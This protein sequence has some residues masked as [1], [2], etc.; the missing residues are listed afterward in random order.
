MRFVA[1]LHIHSRYARATS[2]ELTPENL[3]KWAALKGITIVGTGDFTHPIWFEELQEKLEPAETGLYRLKAPWRKAVEPVLPPSCRHDVRFLLSVEISSIYKKNGRTRKV[4]NLVILP[5]LTYVEAFNRR[6]GTIGNLKADGRPILGLDSRTLLEI[7]LEV[8]PEVLFIPAHIWTP[9]F[10]VLGSES[11]FDSLEE[12]F[13]DLLP[14]IF[15]LET[16][17]SSDPLMNSRLSALDRFVMVSNSDAHSPQKLARE[18]TCFDTELS[19][20]AMYTALKERDRQRFTGT[21]EFYPEEGKYHYDGHRKCQVRWKPAQTMQTNG[22]CPHCGGKLT[23]GVLHR[24]ERLADRPEEANPVVERPFEYLIPLPEVIGAALGVGP[25]SKRVTTIYTKLLEQLGP[26]L[27]ILRA[28]PIADIAH[29]GEPLVAEALRRM[30]TGEVEIQA[31]YD[32]E[33]GTIQIFTATEREQLKGQRALFALPVPA[34]SR[35]LQSEPLQAATPTMASVLEQPAYTV[36]GDLDPAQRQAVEAESGPVVVVAGPGAG[37]TRTLTQR[38]AYLIRQRGVSSGQILAVTFTK[39]AAAEMHS[40]L[41]ALLPGDAIDDLCLGTFHR[42]ALDLMRLYNAAPPKT[43]LDAWEARQLLATALR[44][45]G[46]TIRLQTAQQ[47]ISL[48]KAAGLRPADI[49]GD[50]ALQAAYAAY[51]AQLHAY[52]A[53]DYDDILLDFLAGLETQPDTAAQLRQRFPYILVDEFQDVNAV[54]Y[55]LVKTLAGDGRGLFVI[56]DP[57]Q[58]IYGFRGADP[59]HF[60]QLLQ[61]FPQT[62]LFQ[63]A[64]NYRSTQTIVQAATAVIAHNHDRRPLHPRAMGA[65]GKPLQLYAA[66][67]E[68]A[69]GIA[70]VREISRMVGGA[71]MVQADQHAARADH[72]RSFGDFGV[73]VRTG[74][75]AEV[76]EQCFLQEGLPYRLLGQTSFLDARCVRQVLAFGRYVLRPEDT[77]RLLQVLEGEAF[78]LAPTTLAAVRQ[79]VHQESGSV[80]LHALATVVP[81]ASAQLQA[82]TAA[83]ERYR[84][85][86]AA[87]PVVFLQH[88]QEEY[89]GADNADFARLLRLAEQAPSL[90]GLLDTI[91]LG[92]E[93]DYEYTSA[94][95]PMPVEA[96][97]VMTMHAA[98]GLEFPVV[99]ICGA[100]EG[101]LPIQVQE[102]D[103]EEERR[104]FY[105]GLTRAREE[106]ILLRARSRLHRGE[107]LQ[108]APSPFV[109]ELPSALLVETEVA[110]PHQERRVEQ[111]SLF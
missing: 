55:Q 103:I 31:G 19:Y 65:E 84:P 76:L 92:K 108:P 21:L 106:V 27:G 25:E 102:A 88:W 15:A 28:M 14:H 16:G 11:G 29:C 5:D 35:E 69:E 71:D 41:W 26:E 107:R 17:L 60:W 83:V 80:A 40:R 24:V 68:L 81:A 1:D 78:S 44:E 57:D 59:K 2:R 105:V 23:V 91:V 54:Q 64:T 93:A 7:S 36:S 70:V 67:S 58:A 22:R 90:E 72:T 63:L 79:Q 98:K 66:P 77:L 73:L 51:Q 34:L 111:L 104:L 95:G 101:L 6:L 53:C 110:L 18:A 45:V 109:G 82:L 39:R 8:C 94:T 50:D 96:V 30:R 38:M 3:H 49:T 99:F 9:H 47:E 32:G 10:A 74:R 46:L 48:A 12:C 43:V 52:W 56:G 61:D 62:C 100:E 97:R 4:H 33:Y 20:P 42:L 75:Q 89:G 13:D 86:V 87:S 37:K 85:L